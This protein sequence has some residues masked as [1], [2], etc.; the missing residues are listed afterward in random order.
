MKKV[1]SFETEPKETPQKQNRTAPRE[2]IQFKPP[3]EDT[4]VHAPSLAVLMQLVSEVRSALKTFHHTDS[5]MYLFESEL[6]KLKAR[7]DMQLTTTSLDRE[8]RKF[9]EKMTDWVE[10]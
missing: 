1:V 5:R 8:W 2:F 9:S 6:N 4:K 10:H 3:G 7:T